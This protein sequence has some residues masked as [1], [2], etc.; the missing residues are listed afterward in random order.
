MLTLNKKQSQKRVSNG[1]KRMLTVGPHSF[2]VWQM[3]KTAQYTIQPRYYKHLTNHKARLKA[4][5][6]KGERL[7]TIAVTGS[8]I[9]TVDNKPL[10]IPLQSTETINRGNLWQRIWN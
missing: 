9:R 10:A 8:D 1:T 2:T 4:P 7:G 3:Q 5:V 6:K